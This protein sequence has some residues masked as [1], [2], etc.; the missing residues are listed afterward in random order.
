MRNFIPTNRT[1]KS[2]TNLLNTSM[3][4]TN[5]INN[6][7]GRER[8]Y[9]MVMMRQN[10]FSISSHHIE[11][12]IEIEFDTE[13]HD[14]SEIVERVW[15]VT[16]GNFSKSFSSNNVLEDTFQDSSI[17]V[18][19]NDDDESIYSDR[20]EWTSSSQAST[21]S[22]N[23]SLHNNL[24]SSFLSTDNALMSGK[25]RQKC[26][27]IASESL[28]S[29]QDGLV[30]STSNETMEESGNRSPEV[31]PRPILS[32]TRNPKS[33]IVL[34]FGSS[35]DLDLESISAIHLTN[36]SDGSF[37]FLDIDEL[38]DTAERERI[39]RD[40]LDII[41]E[42]DDLD[43]E[44]EREMLNYVDITQGK[45]MA[46]LSDLQFLDDNSNFPRGRS[47]VEISVGSTTMDS[48]QA[49]EQSSPSLVD[50]TSTFRTASEEQSI[51]NVS[52]V[53]LRCSAEKKSNECDVNSGKGAS[54]TQRI[55]ESK[56][57]DEHE[58]NQKRP[59]KKS[60]ETSQEKQKKD[61]LDA[62]NI[63]ASFKSYR[64]RQRQFRP[65]VRSDTQRTQQVLKND[66][67]SHCIHTRLYNE[68]L[69]KK[70]QRESWINKE[71]WKREEQENKEATFKPVISSSSN[72]ILRKRN[73]K[74]SSSCSRVRSRKRKEEY[75]AEKESHIT[76]RPTVS[77]NSKRLFWEQVKTG[78]RRIPTHETLNADAKNRRSFK[79][80]SEED[81]KRVG[82]A[83]RKR[84]TLTRIEQNEFFNRLAYEPRDR[85]TEN[86]TY[87]FKPNIGDKST[88]RSSDVSIAQALFKKGKESEEKLM[89]LQRL[90]QEELTKQRKSYS[91]KKS[92]GLWKMVRRK[93]LQELLNMLRS[94]KENGH[95]PEKD[96]M[97]SLESDETRIQTKF[98]GEMETLASD[99]NALVLQVANIFE[100]DTL[101]GMSLDEFM[102]S[103][104]S[105]F[106]TD[107]LALH[108]RNLE[109]GRKLQQK[110]EREKPIFKPRI[111]DTSSQS[112]N[113]TDSNTLERILR[114]K[115]EKINSKR[116]ELEE[117][118]MEE[119]TF[120]PKTNV[121]TIPR[122]PSNLK[123]GSRSKT[124]RRRPSSAN[125]R[126]DSIGTRYENSKSS[127][128][129]DSDS[130]Y[131]DFSTAI[132][133][134]I[135][136]LNVFSQSTEQSHQSSL[137]ANSF[138]QSLKSM[139]TRGSVSQLSTPA[140]RSSSRSLSYSDIFDNNKKSSIRLCNY[141]I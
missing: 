112:S 39:I 79:N 137:Q 29:T 64:A 131:A 124:T 81:D 98:P 22:Q 113:L 32:E 115:E 35:Q 49:N 9:S 25:M 123:T 11:E 48:D 89:E 57:Q 27:S 128:S 56:K 127:R 43:L 76:F 45:S 80:S 102:E 44:I 58:V 36:F 52:E 62:E 116:Q 12:Q 126:T 139:S 61:P 90:R 138:D 100:W 59:K 86:D 47:E 46:Q 122:Y 104:D 84:S 15:A 17:S 50:E 136:K 69:N 120:A 107:R 6:G 28:S 106:G 141:N 111:N 24:I 34:K 67:Q 92:K 91:N 117:K 119:C 66:S 129:I 88:R 55:R 14:V 2:V 125:P 31:Y 110:I 85:P 105:H 41:R 4:N 23:E 121:S 3:N 60:L 7:I 133:S 103:L 53:D 93:K 130:L 73:L 5:N 21:H 109:R 94:T 101:S 1:K 140:L 114:E 37:P 96:D 99:I 82:E 65:E 26:T 70:E 75:I 71:R 97:K 118:E 68:G 8:I 74:R 13:T 19:G 33:S 95:W 77:D 20:Y 51:H 10:P 72:E 18:R 78:K 38:S 132:Q 87:T 135:H 30:S 42:L 40:R 16:K 108:L 54:G 83:V 134:I 63:S